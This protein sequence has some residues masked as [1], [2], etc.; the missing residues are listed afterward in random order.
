[1]T[2]D[3]NPLLGP[4]PGVPGF[5]LAAGLSLNGFGGAGGL[6]KALAELV[7]TGEAEVDVQPY[8]PW[9][10]GGPY[11]DAGFAAAGRARGLQVL[12]PPALP[13][14]RLGGGQAEAAVAAARAAAGA[15]R[16][17]RHEERLGTRRLLHPGRAWRRA[18]E[19]QRAFGW[20]RPPFHDRVAVEHAAVRER[21]GIVDMTSFGKLEV[22]GAG[23][24]ALLERACG[25]R[26]DRPV[27]SVVYT[28]LLDERGRIV[29]RRHGDPAR[30]RPLPGRHGCRCRRL[31]SRLPRV[32][33]RGDV[34]IADVTDELAVIGVWGPSVR[35]LLGETIA[36]PHRRTSSR[37][38]GSMCSHSGSPTSASSATSSTSSAT[39][40]AGL[41]R[42]HR[43]RPARARRLPRTR[44]AAHREGLPLLRHRSDRLGH[45]VR[46]GSRLRGRSRQASRAGPAPDTTAA[47]AAGRRRRHT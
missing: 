43:R 22:A 39:C 46:L 45:P 3:G 36:L 35:E 6:G 10:F 4:V 14:R 34:T 13:L 16:G 23:A 18:G 32:P 47:H 26:I 40:R 31:G 5:W 11:R 33:G 24:L 1:M 12:L 17:L 38:A 9:R 41:G 37:S 30:G 42:A 2:P 29:G 21:M 20:S 44:L 25:N 15:R 28:Q 27:G 19:E 7:T 8:R